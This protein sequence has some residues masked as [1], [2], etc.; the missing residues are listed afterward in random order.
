[1]K[2]ALKKLGVVIGCRDLV[3]AVMEDDSNAGTI[4]K[5]DIH[6]LPGVIEVALTA[7]VTDENLA[8]D[9]V[10]LYEV[11]TSLDGFDLSMTVASVGADGRALLLGSK[12]DANGVLIE[13]SDDA[14][15]YVAVGFKTAR[16]DGS[17]DYIWLY[18]GK[19]AQGDS[20]FRTKE[21]GQVNWQTPVLT[22]TFMPRVSD[23]QIRAIVNS[24][25]EAAAAILATFF[26]EV[27]AASTATAHKLTYRMTGDIPADN[28][29]MASVSVMVPDGTEVTVLAEPD[30]E[31]TEHGS[32]SGT[33]AFGGWTPPSGVTVTAGKFTMP[34]GNVTFT[35]AW[36]F[37][38]GN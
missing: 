10:P 9:D 15:P 16:S 38:P 32:T 14:A 30:T 26:D 23:K 3:V 24:E 37:T 13:A 12:I 4:Y 28:E 7:Q 22:G 33:F 18:K 27:Y 8:A 31:A 29:A 20:T 5:D 11:L 35:G 17:D 19:F 34:A 2:K 1:M 6:S 25:E 21:R 36:T